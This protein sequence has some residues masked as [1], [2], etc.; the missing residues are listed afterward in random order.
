MERI[1]W[2]FADGD[3]GLVESIMQD[4]EKT[5]AV[6]LKPSLREKVGCSISGSDIRA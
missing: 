6:N 4:F 2:I 5:K 1:F 3:S